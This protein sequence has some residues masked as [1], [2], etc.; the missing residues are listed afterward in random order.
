MAGPTPVS[1]LMHAATMVT[2][3]VYLLARFFPL[4]EGLGEPVRVYIM[5]I[6]AITL[7]LTGLLALVQTDLK[8]VLAYSTLSQLG[9]M[10][11]A[12]GAGAYTAGIFHLF[13]HA[14]FKALL[15][16][17]AGSVIHAVHS[18]DMTDMGGI[19]KFMPTTYKTF[20]IGSIALA[21]LPPLAGF[22]SKDEILVGI[23]I[24][25]VTGNQFVLWTA[26]AGA[27]ITPLYMTRAI[28]LTFFGSYKGHGEPHEA[29][30]TMTIP[31]VVLAALS[32]VAGWVNIPGVYTG[33][34]TW[35][36]QRAEEMD[37]H[38]AESFDY[39]LLTAGVV[40]ALLGV[41]VG[42][43]LWGKDAETQE[44]RDTFEIPV[45]YP[46]LR[47]KYYLDDFYLWLVGLIKGPLARFVDW[48]NSYV[49]DTIVNAIGA[50]MVGLGGIVYTVLDQ[51]GIDLFM[52]GLAGLAG[53][54]GGKLRLLQTGRVQ[55][56]AGA[57]VLGAVVLVIAFV[58]IG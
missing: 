51:K 37:L 29:P 1:A 50:M 18:N 38:H 36:A 57:F 10:V 41:V 46:L 6:G 49:I 20:L 22:F 39:A 58:A 40:A 2:A 21:G 56:Y 15:F 43:R 45:L 27:F 35:T 9:Y 17:A 30:K 26:I 12:M 8:K 32:V 47:N 4:Y 16:L 24:A 53:G 44:A 13:T 31:L 54:S 48:V 5:W 19:R 7:L 33:F 25:N 23:D 11:T 55:Q 42:W 34:A 52:N 14:F 3:G 28:A